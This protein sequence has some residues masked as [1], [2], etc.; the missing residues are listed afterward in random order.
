VPAR[1]RR[2]PRYDVLTCKA[3]LETAFS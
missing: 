1:S 3:P 2:R